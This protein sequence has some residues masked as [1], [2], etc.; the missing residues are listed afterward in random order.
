[1][2][3]FGRLDVLVNNAGVGTAV[4]ALRESPDEFR[5]CS[6]STCSVP[7]GCAQACARVMEPGSGIVTIASTL[8]F[9]APLHR[10]RPTRPARPVSSD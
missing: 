5:R 10:R 6:T 1:V 7:T 8:A 4:P 2:E 3:E 9:I